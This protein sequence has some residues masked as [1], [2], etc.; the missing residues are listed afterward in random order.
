MSQPR[1]EQSS[2][3]ITPRPRVVVG[4]DGSPE[5]AAAARW[6]ADEAARRH[7]GLQLVYSGFLPVLGYPAMGY[8]IGFVEQ[9]DQQ[10]RDLLADTTR[11]VQARQPGLAVTTEQVQSD[12]RQA[13]VDASRAASLTVLGNRGGGRLQD[14]MV[15]SVALH[16]AAHAYSP[17]AVIPQGHQLRGGPI[18]V[19]VDGSANS[20]AAI[21]FAFDEAAVR[22]VDLVAILTFDDWATQGMA[23][24]PLEFDIAATQQQHAV[25]SEELA[26]WREKYPDVQVHQEVMRGQAADCLVGFA[27][28]APPAQRPQM[29]VVGSRGRGGLTGLFLGSTSHALISHASCPVVV[30]RPVQGS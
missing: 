4:V 16:V 5:S 13:L 25:M 2:A 12:P 6:A 18:L 29:I 27:E 26:G 23:S 30:V 1:I 21:A 20:T 7:D 14:V 15:G 24:R 19:G 3:N 11:E 8:P 17:V 22:G 28:H 9:A 10:G